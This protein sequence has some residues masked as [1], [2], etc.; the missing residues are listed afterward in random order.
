MTRPVPPITAKTTESCITI[1]GARECKRAIQ[2]NN[3]NIDDRGYIYAV[4]RA[5]TG[6]HILELTGEARRIAGFISGA[7]N[8]DNPAQGDVYRV[9][10]VHVP[11]AWLAYLA[12]VVVFLASERASYITGTVL[13]VVAGLLDA[14]DGDEGHQARHHEH[15]RDGDGATCRQNKGRTKTIPHYISYGIQNRRDWEKYKERLDP[16]AA[17]RLPARG[18]DRCRRGR[19][20]SPRAPGCAIHIPCRIHRPG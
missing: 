11:T 13:A 19:N 20:R 6:L 16:H 1:D 5:S 12:F 7:I 4:D 10:Y 17:G 18:C 15:E 9:I 14:G 8:V 2:T 3:V